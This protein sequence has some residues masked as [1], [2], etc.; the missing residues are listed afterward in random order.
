LLCFLTPQSTPVD[1]AWRLAML[2]TGQSLFLSPN[3]ASALARIEKQHSGITS[4]MLATA[5]N[6]GMLLGVAF[7]GMVFG[8]FFS[9]FSGGYELK[10]FALYDTGAFMHA[11][12]ITLGG[13]ALLAM[14][15]GV[16]S[17]MRK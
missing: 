1:I 14:L 16:I 2:G 6:I 15:G 5:R 11:F 17:V 3:T 7:S 12:Q 8:L 13:A 9:Y 10:Q 4:G